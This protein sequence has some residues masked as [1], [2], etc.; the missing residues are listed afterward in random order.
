MMRSM[1]RVRFSVTVL[2]LELLLRVLAVGA[3]FRRPAPRRGI[4]A[5]LPPPPL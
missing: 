3:L 2:L 1:F 4:V 5:T